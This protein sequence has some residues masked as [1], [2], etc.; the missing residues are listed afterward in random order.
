MK[1]LAGDSV[2][3]RSWR[4][5]LP[6]FWGRLKHGLLTQEILDRLARAGLIIYPY[7]VA[8]ES[9]E[10]SGDAQLAAGQSI[11][12]LTADDAAQ[13]LRVDARYPVGPFTARL[14]RAECLGLFV[15]AELVGY[16]WAR[17]DRVPIPGSAG[18]TLFELQ[19]HEAYLFDIFVA[20]GYRGLRLAD[21]IRRAVHSDL[22]RRGRTRFYSFTLAFNRSPRRLLA[23]AGVRDLELR[24]FLGLGRRSPVGLDA[25]LWRQAPYLR[26]FRLTR[27][28]TPPP[29]GSND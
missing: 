6:R 12:A 9:A 22:A 26:T 2:R 5:T 29:A 14:A 3:P 25:R 8:L 11:R 1:T 28:M 19:A 10:A 24:L 20:V 17:L 23:R 15:G 27:V 16:S 7:F 21:V 13:M 18:A 4:D